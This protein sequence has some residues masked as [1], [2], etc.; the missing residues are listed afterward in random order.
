MTLATASRG[1]KPSPVRIDLL[2]GRLEQVHGCGRDLGKKLLETGFPEWIGELMRSSS[3]IQLSV[4]PTETPN[5]YESFSSIIR[6]EESTTPPFRSLALL[7]LEKLSA[8]RRG[9]DSR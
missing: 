8:I 6:I 5:Q 2:K 1:G 7:L 4:A 3:F 9:R